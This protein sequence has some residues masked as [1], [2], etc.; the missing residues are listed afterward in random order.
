MN[1]AYLVWLENLSSPILTGQV[2]EVLEEMGKVSGRHNLYLFA[3]QPLYRIIFRKNHLAEVRRR[4]RAVGSW[5]SL[6]V[7]TEWST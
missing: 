4:L 1:I 6:L 5:A 3:F 7:R 2:V